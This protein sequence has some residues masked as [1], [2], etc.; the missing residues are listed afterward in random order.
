V[1]GTG[2]FA[3]CLQHETDH[4]DG[5]L[6][7]DRLIGRHARAAKK[8]LKANKWGVPGKSW[9]PEPCA[10]VRTAATTAVAGLPAASPRPPRCSAQPRPVHL[11]AV[12]TTPGRA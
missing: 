11:P 9:L 6:Y 8:M 3:R 10:T 2:Y 4:L 12:S 7:L 1:E 5:Y